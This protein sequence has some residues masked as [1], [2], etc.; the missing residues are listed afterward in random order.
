MVRVG[1][2]GSCM[3]RCVG[4]RSG[5]VRQFWF[6]KVVPGV[7]SLGGAVTVGF[8]NVRHGFLWCVQVCFGSYGPVG[9]GGVG[10]VVVSCG[11]AVGVRSGVFR[12]VLA[13]CGKAVMVCFCWLFSKG[14]DN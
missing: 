13:G 8:G 11:K 9:C 6:G 7:V 10:A 5:M 1:L 14:G 3:L 4:A 12:P 2:L